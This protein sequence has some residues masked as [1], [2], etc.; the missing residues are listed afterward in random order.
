MAQL[1]VEASSRKAG[2][3]GLSIIHA[4]LMPQTHKAA[5]VGGLHLSHHRNSAT[6]DFRIDAVLLQALAQLMLDRNVSSL[7]AV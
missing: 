6:Q 4:E 7:L 1:H 3:S 2:R 5:L